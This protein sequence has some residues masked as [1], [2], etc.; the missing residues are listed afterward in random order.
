MKNTVIILVLSFFSSYVFSQAVI[1][2]A[3][4]TKFAALYPTAKVTE[5]ESLDGFY[6]ASFE[7]NDLEV[8]VVLSRDGRVVQTETEIALTLLPAGVN[9]YFKAK[10]N[11]NEISE[12]SKI[13]RADGQVT[14]EVE[15]NNVDYL[16]DDMGH[17]LSQQSEDDDEEDDDNND[18]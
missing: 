15:V 8:S 18:D 13:V 4:K 17:Y 3:V 16:F 12:A 14:F 10:A 7:E 9:D 5:W 1:P 11:G 6:E 2:D